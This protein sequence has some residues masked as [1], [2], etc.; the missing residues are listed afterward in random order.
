MVRKLSADAS[1][2]WPG[3]ETR[4]PVAQLA[5]WSGTYQFTARELITARTVDEV[6]RAV[7]AGG[8]VRALGTR[9]SFNDLADN[10]ATLVSVTGIA[11]DPVLDQAA[12]TVT[13]GAGMSYGALATWLQERGWALGNLGSLPH[14]SVAG[15]AA[16]GTHGS[17]SGNQVL[18]AA[19]AGLEYVGAGG[20]LRHAVR[21][22]P[23]FAGLAVGLGAFGVVTRVSLDVQPGYL[24]RQDAYPRLPWDRVL[25]ELEAVMAA[26]Y[27]VSLFTDWR[28]ESLRAAWVKRRIEPDA[29]PDVPGQFFGA[30]RATG[31]VTIMDGA[32]GNLTPLGQ[33]GPWLA[34]LPHFRL[35][36]TP[37]N[38]DEIQS[39]YFVARS[40]GAAALTAVRRIADRISPLLMISEIRSTAADQLWLSGSYRRETLA[41]H[42]TWRNRPQ[43]VDRAVREVE[44]ALEPFAARPHW[45]KVN[46][47]GP[48]RLPALYPRLADARAL[49]DRLDPA[50]VFSNGR[51]E[52]LGVRTPR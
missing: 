3:A 5:N 10:G 48:G 26:A 7:A 9:H 11:P 42:F 50:G 30:E 17:G 23:D 12:G 27:S 33:A 21:A 45:G 41:V 22:D 40:D 36:S 49:F 39:E 24:V 47:V 37:S 15:A 43:E 6:R 19:L 2:G 32:T 14:I 28:G 1:R 20:E 46:H 29:S 8:R 25:A 13:A 51:L 34:G 44:A 35:D 18:P 38:G 4:S 16:T 52:R 31:P